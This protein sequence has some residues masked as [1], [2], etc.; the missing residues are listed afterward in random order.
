SMVYMWLVF[1]KPDPSFMCNGMLAGLVAI[2][3]PCA[4]LT[5]LTSVIVGAISGVLVIWSCLFWERIVKIDDPVGAVSVHGVNGAWG[6]LSLG[7]FA[8]GTYGKGLNGTHWATDPSGVLKWVET[9]PEGWTE[10]GVTGF[11]YGNPSQLTASL[12]GIA[13]NI[14]W[15]FV[16]SFI[17]FKVID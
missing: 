3:A 14:V 6:I 4:F 8:D 5:P 12:T 1:G 9:V 2:T 17:M 11:F 10:V 16:A 7:L 15:V 13:V